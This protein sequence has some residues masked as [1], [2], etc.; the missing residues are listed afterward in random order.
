MQLAVIIMATRL[1]CW[2]LSAKLRQPTVVAEMAAG[3]LIGP[4][5]LGGISIGMLDGPL[6]PLAEGHIPLS[7]E[8]YG[9]A[10]VGSI[11]LLFVSG[12][13]TDLK[14]FMRFI[15]KGSVVGIGGI[16][17][18]FLMGGG[19]AILFLPGVDSFLDPAALFLGAIATATSLGITARIL[20]ER[21]KLSSP[22][23]VTILSAAVLDDVL[24]I[25][26]LAIIVGM[27]GITASGESI[28]WADIGIV[29]LKAIVF[30]V[31]CTPLIII[32]AP[33]ISRG[34]KKYGSLGTMAAVAFGM[35]L[36]LAGLAELSGLAMIIGA[37]IT[38]LGFSQT[39]VAHEIH[40]RIQGVYD[41]M[42][43]I[44]FCVM[45]MMVDFAAMG[46]VLLFG[47]L[48]TLAA[49]A[50]KYIGCGI[51][52]LLV[53]FNLRGALR[54][55]S[56][57]QPRGEVTLIIAGV[58]LASGA[59]AN[60]IFS[61]AIITL[62]ISAVAAP[63][64]L[65]KSFNGGPGYRKRASEEEA[66]ES[67]I[68]LQFPSQRI[69]DFMRQQILEAFR[70]EGF[71]IHR[72]DPSRK[73]Y[74][75]RS[76]DIAISLVLDAQRI[77]VSTQPEYEQFVRLLMVEELVDLKDFLITFESMKSPDMMGADLVRGM[78]AREQIE[79]SKDD[80]SEDEPETPAEGA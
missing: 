40:E 56:G 17:V 44:F 14:T 54:I 31:V 71:Y 4:Y 18:S 67:V 37:Y 49:A 3:M 57:M 29:A 12:L 79:M 80:G 66:V 47:L 64:L 46:S 33:R 70:Q 39:D 52:S 8:L 16:L 21:G 25:I 2:L 65:V 19:A 50:G 20:S 30:W 28:A 69:A 55:G 15:G 43:P 75:I 9:T 58:G 27:A 72:P 35:A 41:F 5:L 36:F 78:F 34:I 76:E 62:L 11:I 1:A 53:G 59:I 73:V 51:P 74:N 38:G 23:G 13:E 26:I 32:A 22:E 63:V 7:P 60:D 68:D 77:I 24:S 45:G 10:T 6:F 61:V 42:V 48:F